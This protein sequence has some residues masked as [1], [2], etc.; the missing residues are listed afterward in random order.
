ME[1]KI[2]VNYSLYNLLVCC[3]ITK[4]Q[5]ILSVIHINFG[6]SIVIHSCKHL[7]ILYSFHITIIHVFACDHLNIANASSCDLF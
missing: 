5:I 3:T 7:Y 4:Q 1:S 6:Y 2:D